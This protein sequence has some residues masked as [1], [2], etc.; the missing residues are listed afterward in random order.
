MILPWIRLMLLCEI[1]ILWAV[2]GLGQSTYQPL[3]WGQVPTA[4]LQMTIYE[5]DSTAQA[6]V[7]ADEGRQTI[8]L[9]EKGTAEAFLRRHRRIKILQAGAIQK[10]G[11]IELF[12]YHGE[13]REQII[14]LRA[15]A[16]SSDNR[17]EL[18]E[19]DEI[20]VTELDENWTKVTLSFPSLQIGTIIEYQFDQLSTSILAP[21]SWV[22]RDEI[23]VRSSYFR[24]LSTLPI[25]Y[26]FLVKGTD[27]LSREVL[28]D[29]RQR[30]YKEK[31]EFFV[32]N[33]TFWLKNAPSL[34]LEPNMPPGEDFLLKV[35]FVARR[36]QSFSGAKKQ[37][38]TSWNDATKALLRQSQLGG[39]YL[40]PAPSKRLVREF[41]DYVGQRTPHSDELIQDVHK[42]L[43]TQIEW[44][45]S[46]QIY[47]K[48]SPDEA[49]QRHSGGLAEIQ[50]AA[51]SILLHYNL[52]AEPILLRTRQSGAVVTR[53][54]L[55]DQFNYVLLRAKVNGQWQ[56]LDFVNPGT[57]VHW[58]NKEVLQTDG[59]VLANQD[60]E[61]VTMKPPLSYTTCSFVGKID[62]E[63]Q[64]SGVLADTL[65][66]YHAQAL[67]LETKEEE[68]SNSY[69]EEITFEA[70]DFRN[71]KILDKPLV[72]DKEIESVDIGFV[73]EEFL[74]FRPTLKQLGSNHLPT[75]RHRVHPFALSY[76]IEEHSNYRY[77]LPAGYELESMPEGCLL[78]TENGLQFEYNIQQVNQQLWLRVSLS[79]SEVTYSVSEYHA[80]VKVSEA[81]N[82]KLEEQI[83][84]RRT[85]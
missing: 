5:Q 71:R 39:A 64:L 24:F 38:F 7:L 9:N 35:R 3:E 19:T 62:E 50:Y 11:E 12:Y 33:T 59:L 22:F 40:K 67:R 76:P 1:G 20:Y 17:I 83:V 66:G 29:G 72:I 36:G 26:N 41:E 44:D 42:F 30:Y 10:Y 21:D 15:Q 6:I 49:F 63:A 75:N 81:I 77:D 51:L 47:T 56:L 43:A 65:F 4:D 57:D 60:P 80:L 23:P 2:I 73:Q 82:R 53:Y 52:E 68:L 37:F 78:T 48:V 27:H 84:L 45:G 58:I 85:D 14:N 8:W 70:E 32:D 55:V 34:Q 46:S 69:F 74:Y 31:M 54:P 61:W 18:L 25:Y 16:I 79:V 28:P 13:G